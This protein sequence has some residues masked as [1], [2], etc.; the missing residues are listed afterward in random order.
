MNDGISGKKDVTWVTEAMRR[1]LSD[2]GP[3]GESVP[4]IPCVGCDVS[5]DFRVQPG[6]FTSNFTRPPALA[7]PLL[8]IPRARCPKSYPVT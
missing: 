7:I 3:C 5:L 1:C 2:P 4:R 6:C 8:T